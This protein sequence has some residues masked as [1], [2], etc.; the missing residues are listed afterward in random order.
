MGSDHRDSK[1]KLLY[2]MGGARS[3]STILEIMLSNN[4]RVFGAGELVSLVEDGVIKNKGCSCG[5]SFSDCPVWSGISRGGVIGDDYASVAKG[6]R[7]YDR[8]LGFLSRLLFSRFSR[9]KKHNALSWSVID[10]L[11]SRQ[12]VDLVVDSSKY[13]SRALNLYVS[14]RD[15]VGVVCLTRSSSG[16]MDSFSKKN[17]DEQ[18]PKSFWAA[19]LYILVVNF[20][21]FYTRFKLGDKCLVVSFEELMSDPGAVLELLGFFFKIDVSCAQSKLRLG[22]GFDVG[23]IVTGNRLRRERCVYFKSSNVLIERKFS[24]FERRVIAVLDFF[25]PGQ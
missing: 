17:N 20:S 25:R 9:F 13:A 23:H 18:K 24:C 16:M 5:V 10:F 11:I 2:V 21:V 6:N 19:V 4:A 12:R 22:E 15:D 8:H 3:G 1:V 7:L 14:R